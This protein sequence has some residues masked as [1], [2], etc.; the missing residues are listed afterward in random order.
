MRNIHNIKELKAAQQQLNRRQKE[1]EQTM[2]TGWR[3]LIN[4]FRPS[5]MLK[6]GAISLLYKILRKHF[7][8]K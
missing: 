2:T 4:G 6:N 8:M 5:T 1:L 3:D 7:P